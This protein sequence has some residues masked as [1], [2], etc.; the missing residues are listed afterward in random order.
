MRPCLRARRLVWGQCELSSAV[1][2]YRLSPF[3]HIRI[4]GSSPSCSYGEVFQR[5]QATS[6]ALQPVRGFS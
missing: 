6:T 2:C 3:Q 4:L 1:T 5:L